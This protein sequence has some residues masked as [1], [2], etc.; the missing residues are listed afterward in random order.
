MS[1]TGVVLQQNILDIWQL[2]ICSASPNHHGD[3]DGFDD[4]MGS[5]VAELGPATFWRNMLNILE[6]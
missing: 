4:D 3:D 1:T 2:L 5:V 6:I